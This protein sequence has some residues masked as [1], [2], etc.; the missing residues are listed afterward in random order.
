M[1]GEERQE[2]TPRGF[3]AVR[4]DELLRLAD[5]PVDRIADQANRR[6]RAGQSWEVDERRISDWRRGAHLPRSDE[7]FAAVIRAVIERCRGRVDPRQ[8]SVGLLE[9]S[10]WRRW[11]RDARASPASHAAEHDASRWAGVCPY[12]GLSAFE[13][14]Q[15]EVFYGREQL[16]A[17]LVE[18]LADRLDHPGVLVVSG[19]SGA[20]K[21]SLLRAGLLPALAAGELG[22]NSTTWPVRVMYPTMAP[23]DELARV[24]ADLAGGDPSVI[25]SDL[26]GEPGR[27]HQVMRDAVS[28]HASSP[29]TVG[30]DRLVL[31][32]DQFERVFAPPDDGAED[33]VARADRQRLDFIAA[34]HAAATLPCGPNDEPAAV[35]VIVVRSDFLAACAVYPQLAA[36]LQDGLFL[37]GPMSESELRRTITGPAQQADLRIEPGLVDSIMKDLPISATGGYEAGAL[38]LLSEAMR[39][40]WGHRENDRLTS[41]G[42]GLSGGVIKSIQTSAQ[43]VFKNLTPPQQATARQVFHRMTKITRQG[44]VVRHP[45]TYHPRADQRSDADAVVEAFAAQRLIT[46]TDGT[47]EITHDTL[48]HAWDKLREWLEEDP[49]NR[50]LYSQLLEDADTWAHKSNDSSY[51]YRGTRL[52]AIRLAGSSWH[53]DPDRYPALTGASRDFMAASTRAKI[54]RTR[55]RQVTRATLAGLAV[56][57][58]VAAVVAFQ[59]R[60]TAFA[61]RDIANSRHVA[62]EADRLRTTDISE[63]IQLALAAYRIAPTQEAAGTLLSSLAAPAAVKMPDHIGTIWS[64]V[65]SADKHLLVTAGV[66]G[67]VSLWDVRDPHRPVRFGEPISLGA[68]AVFA[69]AVS[70]DGR[71]LATGNY[72]GSISLWNIADPHRPTAFPK[73][74]SGHKGPVYSVEFSP[75]DG[76]LLVTGGL[77][78]SVR[79]WDL[80]D[81]AHSQQL[82]QPIIAHG[83]AVRTVR[84]NP[85]GRT[86]ATGSADHTIRLWDVTRE[87]KLVSLGKT[88]RAHESVVTTL[89]F[90]PDGRTLATGSQD[91]KIKLWKLDDRRHLSLSGILEGHATPVYSVAFSANGQMLASGA[92]DNTVRIWHLAGKRTL[93][94]L[95]HPGTVE[96]VAFGADE[97]T[98]AV[99]AADGSLRLWQLPGPVIAGHTHAVLSTV[100][101]PKGSVL[102]TGGVDETFRLWDIRDPRQPVP[103]GAPVRVGRGYIN[104]MAFRNDGRVLAVPSNDG[105]VQLWAVD[106]PEA[107][108]LLSSF[109]HLKPVNSVAFSPDGTVLASAS[110]DRTIK[111]WDV[112]DAG[113]PRSIGTPLIGHSGSVASVAFNRDGRTLASGGGDHQLRLWDVTSAGIATPL[114]DSLD[115]PEESV[116]AVA[117]SPDGRTLAAAGADSVVRMWDIADR[118]RP[119]SLEVPLSGHKTAILSLTFSHDGR[120][121]ASA[122]MDKTARVWDISQRKAPELMAVLTGHTGGV[123]SADFSNDDRTLVTGSSDTTSILWTIDLPQAIKSACYVSGRALPETDWNQYVPDYPYG[124]P[125]P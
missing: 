68:G 25:R 106:N 49:I 90:S 59:Q 40:T 79:T 66:D 120:L 18:K 52:A 35:V 11:L 50:A 113:N 64:V 84:F 54:R 111:L 103:L 9:E 45:M 7:A 28:S 92:N 29:V 13:Q 22:E 31:V 14:D 122:S 108:R 102:A 65:F 105:I 53:A 109:G 117:F 76:T 19:A 93:Q 67:S 48:L 98:L 81:P 16:I 43:A 12:R 85:D 123:W 80:A 63:A 3:F 39:V 5:L 46:V 56:I 73:S 61:Q 114:G 34:L 78:G 75:Q 119:L 24:L 72:N 101:S 97:H 20:G 69:V 47:A 4:L 55:L 125:C 95:P 71:V 44:A 15:A 94:T 77:D 99:G 32:V 10:V 110:D 121:L 107:P 104:R 23:L 41:R 74:L 91:Q 89:A 27:A 57:A 116:L 42:Y 60:D 6:R 96:S 36:T 1:S 21:S 124:P 62:V 51:L 83:G 30:D 87:R 58:L 17:R 70:P 38:P 86:V 26:A 88:L 118:R 100:I 33:A 37:V 115:G 112:S 82:G 2:L 8:G